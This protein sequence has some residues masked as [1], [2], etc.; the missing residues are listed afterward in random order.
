MIIKIISKKIVSI[1]ILLAFMLN[2]AGAI[3]S[4]SK[5]YANSRPVMT[6]V[7]LVDKDPKVGTYP[8]LR[9]SSKGCSSVQY[10]VYLYSPTKKVWENVSNG[11]TTA[12]KGNTSFTM[13]LKKPLHEGENSFS[14][15]V[16][17]SYAAPVDK[18][19]YDDFKSFRVTANSSGSG[20]GSGSSG[21]NPSLPTVSYAN[22]ASSEMV[23]GKHADLRVKSNWDGKVQYSVYLYSPTKKVWENATNGYT[24]PV[25]GKSTTS[26][27]LN[28]PLHKGEN[29]FSI[30][31]KREGKP[32]ADKGGYDN[33]L[34]YRINVGEGGS[35]GGAETGLPKIKSATID[36]AQQ[37]IGVKPTIKITSTGSEKVEYSV[38]LYSPTKKVWEDV[39]SGYSSPQNPG[40][41]FNFN[42]KIPL[43]EGD[44]SFSI[45]VKRAGKPPADKGGYDNFLSYRINVTESVDTTL[46][47]IKT[48]SIDLKDQVVGN[49][50]T[51]NITSTGSAQVQYS[52]Y[53]Y[54]PTKKVWEDV[55]NG[56]SAPQN[57]GDVY[58]FKSNIPLHKGENSFSVWVKRA[59][60]PPADK[61]GYDNFLS[62]RINVTNTNNGL[63]EISSVRLDTKEV[64]SMP[65]VYLKSN[66]N[67]DVEYSIYLYSQSKKVWEDVASGYSSASNPSIEKAIKINKPLQYGTNTFSIW[68]KRAGQPPADKGGYDTFVHE[69]V[70]VECNTSKISKINTLTH[71]AEYEAVGTSPEITVSGIAGD[72]S[73][74]SY[75]AFLYSNSKKQWIDASDYIGP[76]QGGT[77]V[78]FRLNSQLEEGVNRILVW[79]KRAW[80]DGDIFEDYKEIEI[81]AVRPAPLKKRIVIDPGHGGKDPGAVSPG[82]TREKDIALQV[83]LKLG[84][85]L[86]S[87]GYEVLYT[88]INDNVNWDSSDQS[89]SLRY[90]ANYA[91][92]NSADL[93]VSLHCNSSTPPGSGTET[94]YSSKN[95]NKDINLA[96]DIQREL[97]K[98]TNLR[99]RGAKAGNFYVVNNTNMPASL[100]ELAFINNVT[101]EA[102]LKDPTYQQNAADGIANGIVSFLSK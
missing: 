78:T 80:I 89:A 26:I 56:Y 100:V 76:N 32:P 31:V 50:P 55:G 13:K 97:I 74:V 67:V 102:K 5:V 53:L 3:P 12:L 54:S 81:S 82:G 43:H 17:K 33:F 101:E 62:Y 49:C 65:T 90:R 85:V 79:S 16:K 45:W 66:S 68:V 51:L 59:G 38:Y 10:S 64:G 47:D 77:N 34:S 42:S 70:N 60:Q 46:P 91:N 61:G 57:P 27:K 20:S 87:K 69:K 9:M 73:N 7:E 21:S 18:G 72:G 14:V 28:I 6:G 24:A 52:V 58:K 96:K 88:R 71:N 92:S 93:F 23:V 95:P 25:D 48:A 41:T 2:F 1:I 29:S 8:T 35:G 99:D 86:T 83:S 84:S 63:P 44:N 30:W 11:Y 4:I 19:G 75:K 39:G 98:T 37:K 40:N 15:W 94:Y 36:L 22:I